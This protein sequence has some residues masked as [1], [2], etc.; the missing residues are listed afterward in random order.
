MQQSRSATTVLL[1]RLLSGVQS[2]DIYA[3]ITM[4]LFTLLALL[5]YPYVAKSSGII[6]QNVIISLSVISFILL[7]AL[8]G[9]KVF[10]LLRRFYIIPVIYLMY[11]QVHAFVRVL[12]PHDYDYLLIATDRAIFQTDPTVWL[13]SFSFPLLT[14]YFQICYFLFY[15]MPILHAIELWRTGQIIK[16]DA[17]I[18]AMTFCYLISYLLYF[19]M[20]AIGPRFTLHSYGSINNELPG[21]FFT[22]ALRA[23]IDVGGGIWKGASAPQNLVNR[24]CMPSGHTMM[25]LVNMLMAFRFTSKL[26]WV[27]FV[28]GTSL[29]ISTVYLRYHYVIDVVVGAVLAISILPMEPAVNRFLRTGLRTQ[30][31]FSKFL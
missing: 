12:N 22:D 21:V 18:R 28:I 19:V 30:K 26:R 10:A 16:L 7:Y 15:L 31:I 5:F 1:R 9:L 13:D 3:A 29:I 23:I 27:F 4:L 20:P 25:T 24:D 14:E 2:Y 11:D 6:V 17:F 8:T